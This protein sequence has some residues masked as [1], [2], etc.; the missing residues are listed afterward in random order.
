VAYLRKHYP[1]FRGFADDEFE[2][3]FN[4]DG[5]VIAKAHKETSQ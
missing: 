5:S 2:V 1:E 3:D 4:P